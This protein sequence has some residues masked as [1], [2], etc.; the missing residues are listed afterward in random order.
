MLCAK[1]VPVPYVKDLLGHEDI[2]STMVYVH[3]TPV[4]LRKA[5]R[6]LGE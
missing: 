6:Q 2:G 4:A 1:G 5:V 3:S